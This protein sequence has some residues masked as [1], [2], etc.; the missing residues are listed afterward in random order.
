MTKYA[1]KVL[2]TRS[3]TQETETDVETHN[4]VIDRNR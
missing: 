4:I 2:V 1:S 3:T